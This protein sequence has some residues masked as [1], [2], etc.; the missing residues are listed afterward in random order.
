[1][2]DIAALCLVVTALLTYL[3]HR[4][5]R[6]PMAIGVMV[7]ALLGLS[8][9]WTPWAMRCADAKGRFCVRSIFLTC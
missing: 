8:C 6:L 4:L 7:T 2:L 3:N 1:M 5:T 9:C